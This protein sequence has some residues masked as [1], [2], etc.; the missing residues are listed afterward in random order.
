M[1]FKIHVSGSMLMSYYF[2]GEDVT[3]HFYPS[4]KPIT[5]RRMD[6]CPILP[7]KL[8]YIRRI[9]DPVKIPSKEK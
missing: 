9:W 2:W 5:L 7:V 3:H 6:P 1:I 4:A 8:G